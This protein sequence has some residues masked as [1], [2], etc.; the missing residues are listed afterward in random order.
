MDDRRNV[1]F[2]S[3]LDYF[4]LQVQVICITRQRGQNI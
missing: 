4:G 2:E 1:T 3:V